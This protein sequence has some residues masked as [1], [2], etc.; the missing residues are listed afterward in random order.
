MPQYSQSREALTHGYDAP[1]RLTSATVT[2]G[3]SNYNE[4]YTYNATSGNLQTKSGLTLSYNDPNHV[5]AATGAGGNADGHDANGNQTTRV[6]G[7]STF[8]VGYDA[9]NRLVSVSGL[10]LRAQFSSDRDGRQVRV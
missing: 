9:E 1:T 8:T 6:I 7:G 5:H 4:S 10:S 2:G 3:P